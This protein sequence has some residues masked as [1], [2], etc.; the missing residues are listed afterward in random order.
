M[1]SVQPTPVQTP[2]VFLP[3]EMEQ[4][5]RLFR[6]S[7][8]ALDIHRVTTPQ[9]SGSYNLRSAKYVYTVVER[10]MYMHVNIFSAVRQ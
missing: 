2:K 1:L 9:P 5:V 10:Y 7:L 8:V 3:H 4:F 6:Y